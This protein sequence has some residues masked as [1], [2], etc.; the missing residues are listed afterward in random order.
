MFQIVIG[1]VPR[2]RS[3]NQ[4]IFLFVPRQKDTC[5]DFVY[6]SFLGIQLIYIYIYIYLYLYDLG[7]SNPP[8]HPP[9]P[10]RRSPD[11]TTPTVGR[12][13]RVPKPDAVGSVSS[14]LVQ[15]PWNL[16]RPKTS[17][18]AN[19]PLIPT[20][21][22]LDLADFSDQNNQI[23]HRYTKSGDSRHDLGEKSLD[24]TKSSPDRARSHRF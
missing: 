6:P 20:S 3:N 12:G 11:P 10:D 17:I 16:T 21:F 1:F 15:N 9:V 2:H 13:S 7:L 5:Y 14:S 4:E 18:L 8:G 19:S 24:L 22:Q 23:R